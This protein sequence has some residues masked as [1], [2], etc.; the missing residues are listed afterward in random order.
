M[1]VVENVE[2]ESKVAS[3]EEAVAG[4]TL[5]ETVAALEAAEESARTVRTALVARREALL[6]ALPA[7]LGRKAR[8]L[9]D[10]GICPA[11][12]LVEATHCP[13]CKASIKANALA[14]L[15]AGHPSACDQCGRILVSL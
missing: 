13:A 15:H 11:V 12:A 1:E 2:R 6:A 4:A 10:R 8:A 3:D 5:A 9:V 14:H 7:D